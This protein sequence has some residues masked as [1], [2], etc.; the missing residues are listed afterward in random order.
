MRD[1]RLS[2]YIQQKYLNLSMISLTLLI[3]YSPDFEFDQRLLSTLI[4][5][6]TPTL[7]WVAQHLSTL[8]S[9]RLAV[10]SA[11]RSIRPLLFA[12]G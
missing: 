1:E 7:V 2:A 4:R 5:K 11:V 6:Q 9:N 3:S 10:R 8:Q 12:V